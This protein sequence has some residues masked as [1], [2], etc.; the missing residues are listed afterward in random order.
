[1]QS[2]SSSSGSSSGGGGGGGGGGG[3]SFQMTVQ[4]MAPS[5]TWVKKG[6]LIAEFDRESMLQR[7]EDY[8]ASVEQTQLAFESGL[9]ALEVTTESREQAEEAALAS[10]EQARLDLKA[11]PV[12]SAITA[13]RRRLTVEESE[14]RYGQVLKESAFGEL[15]E[16]SQVRTA[17]LQVAK[18]K[19]ELERTRADLNKMLIRAPI[20][21][22][23]IRLSVFRNGELAPV[24]EGDSVRGGMPF[25]RV[26][27]T[28]SMIVDAT[29]NQLDVEKVRIGQRANVHFDAFPD[30]VLP[31][32]VYSIGT[33]ANTRQYRQEYITEVPIRLRL[34]EV[35][36]RVIPDLTVG[37]DIIV[38]AEES[39][40]AA[41]LE[42]IFPSTDGTAGS[43]V[44][45][46][47]P[48][49][50]WEQRRVELGLAS[51]LVAAIQSG[52]E[53]GEEIA[54]ARP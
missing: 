4:M 19:L 1:V 49:G 25:L 22:M 7:L 14:A 26:V 43:Y 10:L 21:G 27:D 50:D 2:S 18:R 44:F 6:D 20:D 53:P 47:L 12:L 39:A 28:S 24:A 16:E 38:E 51:N 9:A 52:L 33:V 34:D 41:P 5:G 8:E 46:K 48:N 35:E 45:V 15:T 17:E 3:D 30:L 40:T 32:R 37:A 36:S 31:A 29:V 11:A 54:R 23:L 13:E 42:A